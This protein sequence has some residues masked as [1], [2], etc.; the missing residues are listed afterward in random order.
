MDFEWTYIL[1]ADSKK[2]IDHAV[3]QL[4]RFAMI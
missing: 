1:F 2:T 3:N 4:N